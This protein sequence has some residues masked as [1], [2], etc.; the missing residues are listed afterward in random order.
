MSLY[1]E[2]WFFFTQGKGPK[3]A[4]AW[5]F[6]PCTKRSPWRQ[7]YSKELES[8]HHPPLNTVEIDGKADCTPDRLIQHLPDFTNAPATEWEQS[9]TAML[10]HSVQSLPRRVEVIITE[11]KGTRC[12]T[13]TMSV[14][15]TASC[16]ASTSVTNRKKNDWVT[17][18]FL[19]VD[20]LKA[21]VRFR[22]HMDAE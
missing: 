17:R 5:R 14:M 9:C 15:V 16:S 18:V 4:P 10:Q 8:S 11:K 19:F 3:S 13:S 22:P 6:P 20:D 1:E 12:L 7:G 21:N 2:T